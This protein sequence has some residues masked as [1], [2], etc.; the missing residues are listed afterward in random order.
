MNPET[1][2]DSSVNSRTHK[3][4]T[5]RESSSSTRRGGSTA[6]CSPNPLYIYIFVDRLLVMFYKF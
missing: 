6:I 4:T 2:G 1:Q 5:A 3:R